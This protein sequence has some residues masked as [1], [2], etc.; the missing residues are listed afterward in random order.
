MDNKRTRLIAAKWQI[1]GMQSMKLDCEKYITENKLTTEKF[2]ELLN[3]QDKWFHNFEFSNG[4]S[5]F[6]PDPSERKLQALALPNLK[7]KTVID[8][9]AFDGFFSI[10]AEACG[11]SKVVACDEL[12]WT[13]SN[14][15]SN[16]ELVLAKDSGDSKI[17]QDAICPNA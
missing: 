9:G 12:A 1:E 4:C 14:A 11:A 17:K 2:Q 5:T 10:Q 3:K 13:Y 7:G 15:R 6:G 16:I 8:V